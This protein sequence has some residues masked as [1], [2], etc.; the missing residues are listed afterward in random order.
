M[1]DCRSC[2]YMDRD[3]DGWMICAIAD[4]REFTLKEVYNACHYACEHYME[5]A[6]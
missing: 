6:E 4:A 3:E 2:A 1:S 5:A